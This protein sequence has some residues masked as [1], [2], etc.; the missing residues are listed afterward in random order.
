MLIYNRNTCRRCADYQQQV[1]ALRA[2]GVL[3]G[4]CGGQQRD[5]HGHHEWGERSV[6]KSDMSQYVIHLGSRSIL[7]VL[8]L[9]QGPVTHPVGT[10][11]G[12]PAGT[13][14]RSVSGLH[15]G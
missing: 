14:A 1:P 13:S 5:D 12:G 9:L 2:L 6:L 7:T 11:A 10:S 15:S 4:H 3:A 8:S